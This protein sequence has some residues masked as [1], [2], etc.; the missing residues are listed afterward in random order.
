[1][2]NAWSKAA[3]A[4]RDLT[5]GAPATRYFSLTSVG[6]PIFSLALTENSR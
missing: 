5:S 4:D 6:I 2:T 1:M 3:S